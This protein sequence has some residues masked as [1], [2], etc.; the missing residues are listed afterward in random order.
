[1]LTSQEGQAANSA[2]V[3]HMV[4]LQRTNREYEIQCERNLL[5]QENRIQRHAREEIEAQRQRDE[6]SFNEKIETLPS[7]TP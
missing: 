2:I 3:Q 5:Q 6:R 1:M 7:S 4:E